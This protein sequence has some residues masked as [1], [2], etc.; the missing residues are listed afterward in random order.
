[1]TDISQIRQKLYQ[2]NKERWEL[3]ESIMQTGHLLKASFYERS[4]KCSSPNCKCSEGELHGPFPWIYR[5]RKGEKLVSTSCNTGKVE[6][7]R[8]CAENYKS[9]K[10]ICKNI[11]KA[12]NEIACLISK[13]E[14]IQEIAVE[15]FTK[16]EGEKR[17]RK[18]KR[19]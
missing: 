12:N 14:D 13:I 19:S 4:T 16:K 3:T 5:N 1:M 17:G 2:L 18:S 7:A 6:E 10:E 11:E 15:T 8:Q 9:F